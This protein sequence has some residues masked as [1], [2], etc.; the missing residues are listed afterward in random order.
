MGRM[1]ADSISKLAEASEQKE[2]VQ[3]TPALDEATKEHIRNL[4]VGIKRLIE[5]QARSTD[6]L[7]EEL[8]GELKLVA[9]TI[10]AG[11]ERR[12][13]TTNGEGDK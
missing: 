12:G 2:S 5:E 11:M 1:L 9:R 3:A 13:A 7:A 4:D 8:R 10:S 6:S